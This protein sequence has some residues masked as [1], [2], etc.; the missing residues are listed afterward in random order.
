ML[1]EE[2]SVATSTIIYPGKIFEID[3]ESNNIS[4]TQMSFPDDY[5]LQYGDTK[6]YSVKGSLRGWL[7]EAYRTITLSTA[8]T[9]DLLTWLQ[10]NATKQSGGTDD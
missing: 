5:S 10:S 4:Y 1:N 2:P 3:F 9:G 6:V 8:P 7:D